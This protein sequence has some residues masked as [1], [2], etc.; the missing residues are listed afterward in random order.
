MKRTMP[1]S[2]W[3]V[4]VVGFSL[5]VAQTLVPLLVPGWSLATLPRWIWIV[6]APF[7]AVYLVVDFAH[8]FRS[9]AGSSEEKEE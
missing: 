2:A 5:A 4:L 3:W 7:L 1:K 8:T 9:G 6:S